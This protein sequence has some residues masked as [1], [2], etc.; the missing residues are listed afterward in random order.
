VEQNSQETEEK[1]NDDVQRVF[2]RGYITAG[3]KIQVEMQEMKK[4]EEELR[5]VRF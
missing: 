2:R 4:R 1:E 5:C 3:E